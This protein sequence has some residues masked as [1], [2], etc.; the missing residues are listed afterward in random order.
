MQVTVSKLAILS[1]RVKYR[2]VLLIKGKV[3]PV[4]SYVSTTH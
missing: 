3:V 4:L 1:K 2:D